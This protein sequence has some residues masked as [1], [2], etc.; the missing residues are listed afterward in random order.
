MRYATEKRGQVVPN[1]L[2]PMGR[3]DNCIWVAGLPQSCDDA[4]L[5][6]FF[7]QFGA[8]EDASIDVGTALGCVR[9]QNPHS[10]QLAIQN[11]ANNVIDG[12]WVSV[13]RSES[14]GQAKGDATG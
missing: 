10:V 11:S 3:S 14:E 6:L 2:D 13:T 4:T 8:V 7:W 12:T 1:N 5:A 9:F